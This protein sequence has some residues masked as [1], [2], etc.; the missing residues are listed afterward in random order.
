MYLQWIETVAG[1]M[2]SARPT[3]KGLPLRTQLQESSWK[4][5]ANKLSPLFRDGRWLCF[6]SSLVFFA[7]GRISFWP[8]GDNLCLILFNGNLVDLEVREQIPDLRLGATARQP[9]RSAHHPHLFCFSGRQCEPESFADFI[10]NNSCL[11]KPNFDSK[12]RDNIGRF[13]CVRIDSHET[14]FRT[15]LRQGLH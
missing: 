1:P 15:S 6:R 4:N 11:P 3:K 2:L 13:S 14:L 7:I 9:R 5:S 12:R 10:C 8:K